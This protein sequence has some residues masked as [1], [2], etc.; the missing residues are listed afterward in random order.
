MTAVGR[1]VARTLVR[2]HDQAYGGGPT[3]YR[4]RRDGACETERP[5]PAREGGCGDS[6]WSGILTDS[7]VDQIASAGA[8][9]VSLTSSYNLAGVRG[10]E[11]RF[12]EDVVVI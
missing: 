8:L 12:P 4:S 2:A 9:G 3:G 1:T 6:A 10:D 7:D 5:A 11:Y